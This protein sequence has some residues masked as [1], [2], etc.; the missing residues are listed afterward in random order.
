MMLSIEQKVKK[1]A[2]VRDD[3]TCQVCGFVGKVQVL[4]EGKLV[5]VPCD[6]LVEADHI[7]P[8]GIIVINTLDNFQ[9]R[10]KPCHKEKTKLDCLKIKERRNKK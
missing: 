8:K 6:D 5:W 9:T 10:C 3:Y 2:K 4:K 7:I 1:E